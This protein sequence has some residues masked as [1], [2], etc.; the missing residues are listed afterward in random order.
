MLVPWCKCKAKTKFY[1]P[2]KM[3][4]KEKNKQGGHKIN[5]NLVALF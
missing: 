4:L 5:P 3:M 2:A 1:L